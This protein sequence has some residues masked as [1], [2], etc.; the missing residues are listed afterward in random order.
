MATWEKAEINR[1]GVRGNFPDYLPVRGT[2][3]R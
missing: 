3:Q 2:E 1:F